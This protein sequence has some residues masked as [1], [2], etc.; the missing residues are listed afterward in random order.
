MA[1]AFNREDK[2]PAWETRVAQGT[3]NAQLRLYFN[4]ETR[5]QSRE[6]PSPDPYHGGGVS[7]L[8]QRTTLTE[9]ECTHAFAL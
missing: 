8:R 2:A 1:V 7:S 6:T 9:I 5:S 4:F 3:A